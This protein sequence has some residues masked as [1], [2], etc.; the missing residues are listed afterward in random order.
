MKNWMLG[1]ALAAATLFALPASAQIGLEANG[2]RSE[3]QWGGEV[4]VGYGVHFGPLSL[5]GAAGAFLYQ[6]DSWPYY[7]DDNG[8]STR[9]RNHRNG[10][11]ADRK[12]CDATEVKAYGRL[13]GMFHTPTGFA[14]GVGARLSDEVRPYGTVSMP[15]G[16][17]LKLKA[18]AGEK[19][20]A[21]GLTLGF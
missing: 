6:G 14:L 20:L 8:G 2:A 9:C 11:Y 16:P 7:L 13:E 1:A 3:D 17:K 21:A 4:G 5:R 12:N 19:Y 10:Q 15:I 18:N